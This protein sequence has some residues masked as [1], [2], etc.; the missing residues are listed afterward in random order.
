MNILPKYGLLQYRNTARIYSKPI[1]ESLQLFRE[2][3]KFLKVSLFLSYKHDE[4]EELDSAINFLKG[5]GVL[6]YTDYLFN[7]NN[8][9]EEKST[10]EMSDQQI[11]QITEQ[12]IKENKKFIFLATEEAISSKRC[13]WELRYANTQKAINDIAIL[14]IRE[15]YA[16]YGGA[17]YLHKYPFIQKSD[18][19]P[20]G[21]DVKFPNGNITSLSAWL[22]S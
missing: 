19:D 13:K 10:T 1:A 7:N 9:T 18:S 14:P 22:V 16:D 4:L 11:Q 12:K 17:E 15:D 20:E 8:P 5:F 21:Y 2:E 6:I 3:T